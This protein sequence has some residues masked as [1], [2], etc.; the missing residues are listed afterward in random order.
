MWDGTSN[1]SS[2]ECKKDNLKNESQKG[3]PKVWREV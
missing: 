1:I 3:E 2:R